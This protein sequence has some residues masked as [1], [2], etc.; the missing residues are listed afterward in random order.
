V[1]LASRTEGTLRQ[2]ALKPG[3]GSGIS[4]SQGRRETRSRDE[5]RC[6]PKRKEYVVI[7]LYSYPE[8]SGVADN[9]GYGLI[10]AA[11]G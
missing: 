1:A 11:I 10:H 7:T 9:N 2:Q 3:I 5:Q 8:L 6:A 4:V